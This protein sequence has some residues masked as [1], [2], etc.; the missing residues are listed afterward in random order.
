[1]PSFIWSLFTVKD[2]TDLTAEC[3]ICHKKIRGGSG[4]VGRSSR[5]SFSTTPLHNHT[6]VLHFKEYQSAKEENQQSQAMKNTSESSETS[7]STSDN[8]PFSRS[9]PPKERKIAQPKRQLSLEETVE[10]KKLW[11]INDAQAKE[12]HK[13][14]LIIMALDNKPFSMVEDDGFI[15]LMAHLQPQYL[16]PSRQYFAENAFWNFMMN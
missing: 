3:V 16:I 4:S 9:V 11:D 2:S 6:K 8:L 13:K 1:M 7:P 5:R 15:R 12:I 10:R 14:I